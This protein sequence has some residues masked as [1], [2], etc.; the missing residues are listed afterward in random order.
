MR[1]SVAPGPRPAKG[2]ACPCAAPQMLNPPIQPG[3][4][5]DPC[6]HPPGDRF[7]QAS[8]LT[9][10]N[11]NN[12]QIRPLDDC[13]TAAAAARRRPLLS[14]FHI[15]T[16]A[17]PGC[18]THAFRHRRPPCHLPPIDSLRLWEPFLLTL[19][20]LPPSAMA[21]K[22]HGGRSGSLSLPTLPRHRPCRRPAMPDRGLR[23]R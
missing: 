15:P 8:R 7:S 20:P 21:S 5:L 3:R 1:C 10:H 4:V 23:T 18:D 16:R 2:G 12:L 6:S 13:D 11:C 9:L 19:R 17:C 14:G 22:G